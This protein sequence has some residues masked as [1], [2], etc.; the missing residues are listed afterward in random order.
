MCIINSVLFVSSFQPFQFSFSLVN[1]VNHYEVH[2]IFQD[3][4][5]QLQENILH[6]YLHYSFFMKSPLNWAVP[7]IHSKLFTGSFYDISQ[8]YKL[9]T[10]QYWRY[11]DSLFF[12]IIFHVFAISF[13]ISINKAAYSSYYTF[14]YY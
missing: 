10:S 2:V 3:I 1:M 9:F 5:Y 6:R 12:F 14:F 13:G 7:F 8:A 11:D 4:E